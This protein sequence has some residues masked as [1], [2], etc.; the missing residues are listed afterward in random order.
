MQAAVGNAAR[1]KR[2]AVAL[3][4]GISKKTVCEIYDAVRYKNDR[5]IVRAGSDGRGNYYVYT[6]KPESW[7]ATVC[8]QSSIRNHRQSMVDLLDK[9]GGALQNEVWIEKKDR[10]C[11]MQLKKLSMKNIA[12]EDFKAGELKSHL[13]PLSNSVHKRDRWVKKANLDAKFSPIPKTFRDYYQQFLNKTTADKAILCKALFGNKSLQISLKEEQDILKSMDTL[14]RTYLHQGIKKQPLERLIQQSPQK[15]LLLRFA[16]AWLDHL[17][18]FDKSKINTRNLLQTFSWQKAITE[19]ARCIQKQQQPTDKTRTA[20]STVS[21]ERAKGIVRMLGQAS[22][23]DDLNSPF[24]PR[25]KAKEAS[26]ATLEADKKRHA[27]GIVVDNSISS[28]VEV[29][30]STDEEISSDDAS[31]IDGRRLMHETEGAYTIFANASVSDVAEANA[32][33]PEKQ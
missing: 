8:K 16:K 10:L 30:S 1:N 20:F 18:K 6:A 21:P 9:S 22:L 31:L 24:K 14:L 26:L 23:A 7:L 27:V 3:Q 29:V 28:D 4:P 19:V 25:P 13:K 32:G 15:D 33:L 5:T 2:D 11:L 17:N 12:Q